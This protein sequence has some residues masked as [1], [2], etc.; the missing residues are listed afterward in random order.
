MFKIKNGLAP[1]YLAAALPRQNNT[2]HN[3]RNN[4]NGTLPVPRT[5]LSCVKSSFF[6]S[7]ISLWN[8]LEP[9]VRMKPTFSSFKKA[10][11]SKPQN[12]DFLPDIYFDFFGMAEIILDLD[13][14]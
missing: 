9:D 4:D 6:C 5:R 13:L 12:S 14:G 3:L 10:A 8:K 7:T 1:D 2:G 11:R